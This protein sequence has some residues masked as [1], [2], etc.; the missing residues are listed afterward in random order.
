MPSPTSPS[1][2]P[3]PGGNLP[4]AAPA[5]V[6]VPTKP[7]VPTPPPA[8]ATSMP[9]PQT[10]FTQPPTQMT[11]SPAPKPGAPLPPPGSPSATPTPPAPAAQ[12]SIYTAPTTPPA[13][14]PGV[15]KP[16]SP[17]VQVSQSG[18]VTPLKN[19]VPGAPMAAP[20]AA[21]AAPKPAGSVPPAGAIPPKPATPMTAA[22]P[23][24]SPAGKPPLAKSE[25]KKPPFLLFALVGAIILGLAGFF[26]FNSFGGGS[27]PTKTSNTTAPD[28]LPTVKPAKQTTLIYWGLWEPTEVM[29][30]VIKEFETAHPEYKIDYRKQSHKDFRE[31]LQTAIASGNG[32]DLFRFHASWVPMLKDELAALPANVMSPTQFQKDYY[33]VAT[34]QLTSNNKL[35]GVPLMYDGLSLYYNKEMLKAANAEPPK[36]WAELKALA[37]SLTVPSNKAERSRGTL[38]RAGLAIGNATNVE[39]F[40]DIFGLLV[41]QNGGDLAKPNSTEVRDALLFYTNFVKEDKVWSDAMP[42]ST[43][44]FARGDVAMMFAPSWR[45]LD[46]K[47]MNPDLDFGVA[48]LPQLGDTRM[49]WASYWAEGVNAKSKNQAGAWEFIKFLSQSENL[50]KFYSAASQVRAF[51]EPYPRVDMAAALSTDPVLGALLSDAPVAK[52]WYLN[53][54]THDNGL[55]DQLI[56]Y[57]GD[58]INATVDG[59][60]IEEVLNTLDTGVTQVLRQYNVQ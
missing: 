29:D 8:V 14:A 22:T 47:A 4:P 54:Y 27:T 31:R 37:D 20:T 58:A 35:V 9:K 28:T 59:T 21:P 25:V 41:L 49:A 40:A 2:Q 11:P 10:V 13:A 55:N 34:Q 57:Y 6:P 60:T 15:I 18:Q 32:P 44:A 19:P 33:P 45:A 43:V 1:N 56:K 36:T 39:H 17:T 12:K 24:A 53:S 23:A 26:L 51:G 7:P 42:S 30:E 50:E 48:P 38:Q 46:I 3:I 5:G 52:S 16:G